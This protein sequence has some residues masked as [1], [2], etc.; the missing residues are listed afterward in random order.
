MKTKKVSVIITAY[1]CEK[2]IV[3][4][5][6]SVINQ[7]YK[8]IELIIIDDCSVDKTFEFA[9]EALKSFFYYCKLIKNKTNQ[10]PGRSRNIGIRESSGEW[11]FF[12]D[13]DDTIDKKTIETLCNN[14][15][16][17]VVFSSYDTVNANYETEPTNFEEKPRMVDKK[18]IQK[19]FLRRKTKLLCPGTLYRRL[20]LVENNIFFKD[21]RWSEDQ[22]FLWM[23]L[24]FA[25]KI[26]CLSKPLYHYYVNNQS[27]MSSTSLDRI[28]GAYKIVCSIEKFNWEYKPVKKYLSSRW[29]LGTLNSYAHMASSF[30]E[31]RSAIKL[32]GGRKTILKLLFFPDLITKL[33]AFLM[34]TAPRIYYR[35][36]RKKVNRR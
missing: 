9:Q 34:L 35:V 30:K 8:N 33:C 22:C 11:V 27:I 36:F 14:H 28:F 18:V 10:G 19:N 32:F 16:A 4:A 2:F 20:F 3:R 13:C 7:S 17:D 6:K 31:W 12:L 25:N 15:D 21:I 23:V 29:V 5:I 26:I 1:N 24:S